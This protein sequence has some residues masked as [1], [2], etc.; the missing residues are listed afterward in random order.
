MAN[1]AQMFLLF[2]KK[3][4]TKLKW[5][6]NEP[7]WCVQILNPK[8]NSYKDDISNLSWVIKLESEK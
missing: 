4:S 3:K 7:K 8:K 2:F 6:G 1:T 5:N